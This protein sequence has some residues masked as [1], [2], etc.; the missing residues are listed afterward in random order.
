MAVTSFTMSVSPPGTIVICTQMS[1]FAVL[2]LL[3]MFV[4]L[5]VSGGVWLVQNLT[6]VAD[7]AQ[8]A[9]V[10]ADGS[11][12]AGADAAADAGALA[13]AVV[14]V[15]VADVPQAPATMAIAERA[16]N[17]RNRPRV[18]LI[19]PPITSFPPM[20]TY[21]YRPRHREPVECTTSPDVLLHRQ[22]ERRSCGSRASRGARSAARNS[23]WRAVGP[24]VV[25][26][27]CRSVS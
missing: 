2:K 5:S 13:G 19:A 4:R 20:I 21:R 17:H 14:G 8:D 10:T 24:G 18:G 16:A 15:G 26:R 9:P 23:S 27:T 11:A 6:T 25:E 1:G 3:T 7:A 12:L 22:L